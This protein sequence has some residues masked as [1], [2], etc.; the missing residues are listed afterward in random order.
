MRKR[1]VISCGL[2]KQSAAQFAAKSLVPLDTTRMDRRALVSRE[3]VSE[4]REKQYTQLDSKS[5]S[6][7]VELVQC[8]SVHRRARVAGS[9][10]EEEET[11]AGLM[12][13]GA[14]IYSNITSI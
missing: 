3:R 4:F 11:N 8:V 9:H 13:Y 7:Q 10:F 14:T 12:L 6:G 1:Q 2:K 5:P